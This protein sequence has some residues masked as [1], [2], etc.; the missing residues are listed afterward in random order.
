MPAIADFFRTLFSRIAAGFSRP[1]PNPTPQPTVGRGSKNCVIHNNC[2][3]LTNPSVRYTA[4]SNIVTNG[5]WDMQVNVYSARGTSAYTQFVMA[6]TSSG[7]IQWSIEGWRVSGPNIFNTCD[8]HLYQL[9]GAFL[10]AG[11]ALSESFETD[12]A[13]GNAVSLTFRVSRGSTILAERRVTLDQTLPICDPRPFTWDASYLFVPV[14][15]ETNISGYNNGVAVSFSEAR[16]TISYSA[17]S[18]ILWSNDIPSCTETKAT[19]VET[20]NEAYDQPTGSG[21]TLIQTCHL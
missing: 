7:E 8:Q 3:P 13:S 19:T 4:V 1:A 2:N 20:S 16:A 12:P 18:G 14:A 10:P 15:L 17:A 11:Y 9:P 6:V 21:N 5:N